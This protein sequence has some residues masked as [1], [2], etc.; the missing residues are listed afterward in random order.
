MFWIYHKTELGGEATVLNNLPV[1]RES[2]TQVTILNKENIYTRLYNIMPF[3]QILFIFTH[4]NL[5]QRWGPF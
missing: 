4:I 3:W 1:D 5:T 2:D